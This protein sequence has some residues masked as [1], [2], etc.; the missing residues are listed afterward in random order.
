MTT[1]MQ[2]LYVSKQ[3]TGE[4][5]VHVNIHASLQDEFYISLQLEPVCLRHMP[6]YKMNSIFHY[7][8]CLSVSGTCRPLGMAKLD[9]WHLSQ[10]PE[11]RQILA[12]TIY[13][14]QL[15]GLQCCLLLGLDLLNLQEISR[16]LL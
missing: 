14:C 16:K 7:N 12:L 4:W 1:A 15:F 6:A 3:Y 5:H 13:L 9:E 10:A 11:R 8:L 2:L